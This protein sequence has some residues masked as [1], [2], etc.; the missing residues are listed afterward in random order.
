MINNKLAK[1][2]SLR[3]IEA[4]FKSQSRFMLPVQIMK[5]SEIQKMYER[6]GWKNVE[7]ERYS[8]SEL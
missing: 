5:I 2:S 1:G 7:R 6:P 8:T 3:T 4:T